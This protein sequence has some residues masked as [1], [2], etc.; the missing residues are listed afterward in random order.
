MKFLKDLRTIYY[1]G[2]FVIIPC[3]FKSF[4]LIPNKPFFKKA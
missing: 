3:P 1:M 2:L 4:V